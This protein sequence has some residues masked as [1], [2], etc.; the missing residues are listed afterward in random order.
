MTSVTYERLN[1]LDRDA[2]LGTV[3]PILEGHGVSCHELIWRT[4]GRGRVLV[5]TLDGNDPS[6]E[7]GEGI[8]IA[9][10]SEISRE[11]SAAF[12]ANQVIEGAFYMDVGSPGLERNLYTFAEYE[13]FAGKLAK[14][15]FLSPIEGQ[16][17]VRGRLK[18]VLD[19]AVLIDTE[20]LGS[21]SVSFETIEA[22]HLLFDAAAYSQ[23]KKGNAKRAKKQEG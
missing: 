20:D 10:C 19:N 22:G 15:K 23:A 11:L 21:L 6:K 16:T 7:S 3:L 18:G 1:G 2:L 13:R 17:G 9:V 12:D 14:I 8:T 4:D 5:M